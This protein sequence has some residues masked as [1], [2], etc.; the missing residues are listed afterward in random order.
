V[1]DYKLQIRNQLDSTRK[2]T[3]LRQSEVKASTRVLSQLHLLL[4]EKKD[5]LGR[6]GLTFEDSP[7]PLFSQIPSSVYQ[8][9]GH[10]FLFTSWQM[11]QRRIPPLLQRG[12]PGRCSNLSPCPLKNHFPNLPGINTD[13]VKAKV[14]SRCMASSEQR[15]GRQS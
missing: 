4:D 11:S 7:V 13:T 6:R 14:S 8:H 1:D 12:V 10:L 3:Q 2:T 9:R 5:L 15:A